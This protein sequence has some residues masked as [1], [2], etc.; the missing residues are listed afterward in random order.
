MAAFVILGQLGPVTKIK[1]NAGNFFSY[2]IKNIIFYGNGN[3]KLKKEKRKKTC[4]TYLSNK[5]ESLVMEGS[6]TS[7]VAF[8]GWL[9]DPQ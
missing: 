7:E 2:S 9:D 1:W 6:V 5:L 8:A 3:L 4:Q